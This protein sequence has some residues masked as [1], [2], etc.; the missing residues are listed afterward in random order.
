MTG[1][2]YLLL[3]S[4]SLPCFNGQ[5]LESIPSSS[6]LKKLGETISLSCKISGFTFDSHNTHWIRQ[7]AGKSLEWMGYSGLG[8][9]YHAKRFEGRMETTKDTSNSMMTLMLS[10]VRAEDSAVYY[11]ARDTVV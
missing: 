2:L 6:V 4:L 8:L 11:C 10:G 3:L 7:P 5:N 9:G 1:K